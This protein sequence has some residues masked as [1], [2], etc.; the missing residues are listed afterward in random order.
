MEKP[1][2][3][4]QIYGYTVC[5]VAVIAFL[6]CVANIIPA[7]MDLGDP[8]HA[9]NNF[10]PA[11]TPSL[12]SF[13]NYKMDVLKSA[14][15]DNDKAGLNYIPDDKTLRSMFNA[16]VADKIKA[17]DHDSVR[18]IMVSGLIIIICIILFAVHWIWMR[19]LAKVPVA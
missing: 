3:M 6:I 1:H 12:A 11:G 2:R 15:K 8:M 14:T 10:I 7:I 16:A 5:L 18:A 19:K 9:G 17:A 13:E 4:A